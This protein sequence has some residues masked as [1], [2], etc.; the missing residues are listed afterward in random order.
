MD[1][2]YV[3]GDTVNANPD[4]FTTISDYVLKA[5]WILTCFFLLHC[6]A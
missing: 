5:C 4:H 2:A 6:R 3:R 1:M